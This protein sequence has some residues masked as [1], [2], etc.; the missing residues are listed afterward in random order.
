V[1][2]CSRAPGDAPP[3]VKTTRTGATS[4]VRG[5]AAGT[6]AV[7]TSVRPAASMIEALSILS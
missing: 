6:A 2:A 3:I 7:T 1:T 5:R 4:P